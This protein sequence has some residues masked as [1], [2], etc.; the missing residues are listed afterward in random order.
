[1]SNGKPCTLTIHA[2]LD[3]FPVDIQFEGTLDQLPAAAARLRALGMTPPAPTAATGKAKAE[4]VTPHYNASGA[5][6]CPT[7]KK[8][9][10]EGKYGLYCP[11]KNADDTYCNLKFQE[12]GSR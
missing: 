12:G 5:A 4:R 8:P 2:A 7:H 11:A 6:C 9:L 3:G 10:R 1:M